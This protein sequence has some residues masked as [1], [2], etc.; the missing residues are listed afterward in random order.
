MASSKKTFQ[1]NFRKASSDYPAPDGSEIRLFPT[2]NEGGA[3]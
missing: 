2:M 3:C 1:A